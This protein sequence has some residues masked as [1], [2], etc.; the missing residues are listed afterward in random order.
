MFAVWQDVIIYLV[1]KSL[2]KKGL[3][4]LT[5]R[6][7]DI[8]S[9]AFFIFL[10]VLV[11]AVLGLVRTR[12]LSSFFG[13]GREL[14]IYYAAF[15]IPDLIFQVLTLGAL[16]S[17]FIPV[18]SGLLTAEKKDEAGKLISICLT[19]SVLVFCGMLV[20]V[21]AF[22]RWLCRFLAPGF[23]LEEINLM[24]S[25]TRVMLSVQLFFILGNFLTGILQ[26]VNQFLIPAV[27]PVFYNV[28][29]I[30]GT[31]FLSPSLGIYGPTWGVGLGIL[32]FFLL[33]LPF[34]LKMNF[35]LK[36]DFSFK[37]PSF[38]EVAKLTIPR[39]LAIGA[40][41]IEYTAD[42][43]IASLL[44]AGRYTIFNFAMILMSVPIRLFGLSIGQ[45]SLPTLSALYS[46]K[47]TL[48]FSKTLLMSLRQICFL[49]V[50]LTV[51]I[52]VLRVPF[53]RLAF[54]ARSFVW[55][56][57]II[58]GQ[59]VAALSMAILGQAATQILIRSFYAIR[60]TKTPFLVGLIS[61]SVNVFLSVFFVL[62][63]KTDIVGLAL[64]TSIS[65]IVMPTLLF[66]F[67]LKRKL[68]FEVTAF[69]RGVSLIFLCGIIMAVSAYLPMKVLDAWVFD[70][71]RTLPL[72][73]LTSSVSL[74][75]LTVFLTTT[76]WFKI[77]E[78]KIILAVL[79]RL[80]NWRRNLRKSEE[81]I[82]GQQ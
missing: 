44:A 18:L 70:T 78:V 62:I 23:S 51:L 47:K 66:I 7:T 27:A 37:N 73:L 43:M 49:V 45:A 53:V 20:F 19:F 35:R 55:T 29:I 69:Y 72:L 32:L 6:Q 16:S 56:A 39:M 8:L 12:L 68:I 75:G 28:G 17:A 34:V 36:T 71:T 33:Q 50:P 61:V 10:A 52:V 42:L 57:T 5:S 76:F 48:E 82:N 41:Q 15:R 21:L 64:S 11:S 31:F 2:I 38:I 74:W 40:S 25:L 46:Q 65:S 58:T 63:L 77:D 9:A 24:V 3:R 81:V 80:G 1:F 60:D 14:D 26:S 54:G 67:L 13:A 79:A 4:L 22:A 59:T 30:A